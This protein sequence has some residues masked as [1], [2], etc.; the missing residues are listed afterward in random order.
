MVLS[1]GEQRSGLERFV[2]KHEISTKVSYTAAL[3]IACKGKP[4]TVSEILKEI[5]MKWA[6][7]LFESFANKKDIMAKIHYV[8][9]SARTVLRHV[10]DMVDHADGQLKNYLCSCEIV[11]FTL[12]EC[13]D[14]NDLP[15]C[16]LLHDSIYRSSNL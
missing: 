15:N 7:D 16:Y 13:T 5:F 4:F 6:E 9:L 3:C 12:D 11:S 10:T 2:K 14:I 8:S 1:F